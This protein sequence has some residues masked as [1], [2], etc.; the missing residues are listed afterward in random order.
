MLVLS[1]YLHD[2]KLLKYFI[3]TLKRIT[4]TGSCTLLTPYKLIYLNINSDI[5][6]LKLN[7]VHNCCS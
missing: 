5:I 4:Q 7:I 3:T 2:L 6:N 1:E